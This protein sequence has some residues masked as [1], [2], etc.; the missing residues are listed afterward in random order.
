MIRYFQERMPY[1]L[2]VPDVSAEL[3][4]PQVAGL[5]EL[6]RRSKPPGM[7]SSTNPTVV[8]FSGSRDEAGAAAR[9]SIDN[10]IRRQQMKNGTR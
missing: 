9:R 3:R 8:K 4:W 6:K 10:W 5:G 2:F 7:R 1:G